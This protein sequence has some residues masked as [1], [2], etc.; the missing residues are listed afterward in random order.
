PATDRRQVFAVTGERR[1][2]HLGIGAGGGDHHLD[3]HEDDGPNQPAQVG[4]HAR[5]SLTI[6]VT[7]AQMDRSSNISAPDEWRVHEVAPDARFRVV[8][9][10]PPLPPLLD[11]E[12]ERLWAA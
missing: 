7:L 11:A 6:R 10:M 9:P 3:E 1:Q 8:R 4:S 12:V 2:P 5:S